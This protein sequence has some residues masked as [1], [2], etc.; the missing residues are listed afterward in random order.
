[1]SVYSSLTDGTASGTAAV[2]QSTVVGRRRQEA[3]DEPARPLG[4]KAALLHA[5]RANR[6]AGHKD[7]DEG[8]ENQLISE[9]G[10]VSFTVEATAAGLGIERVQ[11][12]PLG[13][14]F[15]QVFLFDDATSFKRW[16]DTDPVRFQYPLLH[17]QLRRQ[18]DDYFAAK[19]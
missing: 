19:G 2:E 5:R 3:L 17:G 13:T 16:S 1:M 10:A 8:T 14:Q 7:L 11:R 9:D 15:M 6:K 4:P 18:G 12:R